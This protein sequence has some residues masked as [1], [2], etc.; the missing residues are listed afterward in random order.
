MPTQA[1]LEAEELLDEMKVEPLTQEEVCFWYGIKAEDYPRCR[2]GLSANWNPSANWRAP[3][4]TVRLAMVILTAILVGLLFARRLPRG[5]AVVLRV[6]AALL[7]L[8]AIVMVIRTGHL[9]AK[10]A[11]GREEGRPPPGFV[12]GRQ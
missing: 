8:T 5:A 2:R 12:P 1:H 9:G 6:L 11:W 3:R 10:L 7:A 4:I